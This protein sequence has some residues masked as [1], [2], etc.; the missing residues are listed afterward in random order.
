MLTAAAASLVGMGR[1]LKDSMGKMII[2][3]VNA[4]SEEE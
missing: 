4:N 2:R 1:L 3:G